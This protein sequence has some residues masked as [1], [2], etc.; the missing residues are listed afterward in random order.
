MKAED[1]KS[2]SG[3]WLL[4]IGAIIVAIAE[5]RE[6]VGLNQVN[7]KLISTGEAVEALG[8]SLISMTETDDPINFFGYW[9]NTAGAATTSVAAYLQDMEDEMVQEDGLNLEVL[10]EGLQ[11]IGASISSYADLRMGNERS[12]IGNGIQG[13]GS[14]VETIGAV[15]EIRKK[16][17]GQLLAAI[18][19][20]IVA[21]GS[22]FGAI[23]TTKEILG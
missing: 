3:N 7:N 1:V 13:L 12:A 4:T 14:A 8:T 11:S 9:T 10:G 19:A 16:P 6:L 15:F 5:S 17:V 22:K 20:I 21:I 18:G 2:L 23:V